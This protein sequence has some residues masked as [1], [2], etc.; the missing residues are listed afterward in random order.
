MNTP[1]NTP[2]Y[3]IVGGTKPNEGIVIARDRTGTNHTV[4]LN[5]QDW[6]VVATNSDFWMKTDLRH[7]K[8]V[9]YMETIGQEK[10][11]KSNIIT[12]VLHGS[13]VFQ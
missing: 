13:G 11:N 1:I 8:A 3:I 4:S 2:C 12:D 5:D 6:F 7:A 10:I 9:G